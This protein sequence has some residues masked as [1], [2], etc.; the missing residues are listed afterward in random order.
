MGDGKL[1]SLRM[2]AKEYGLSYA[3]AWNH[4]HA[5]KIKGAVQ[6]ETGTIRVPRENTENETIIKEEEEYTVIYSRVSSSQNKKNLKTQTQRVADFC[7]AKGWIVTET[8]EEVGSGLNDTRKKL[9]AILN[10]KKITRIIVEYKDRLT[11]FGFN[12]IKNFITPSCYLSNI[13][14][15]IKYR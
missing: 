7:Y 12:Y 9:T 15:F 14:A 5:G 10:N 13:I 11:R 2:Y 4:F 8:V 3:T 1:I 6:L